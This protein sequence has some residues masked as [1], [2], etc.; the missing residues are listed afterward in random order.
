MLLSVYAM[1]GGKWAVVGV[2]I[3]GWCCRATP[4]I[5]RAA[6]NPE[7]TLAARRQ[8]IVLALI[9]IIPLLTVVVLIS[10]S[11]DDGEYVRRNTPG[12]PIFTAISTL[13]N[14]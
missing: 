13:S 12:S 9:C 4:A 7:L 3:F 2:A 10:L 8:M 1:L 5:T 11:N 14:R 6:G